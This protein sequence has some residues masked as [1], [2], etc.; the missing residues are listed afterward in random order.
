MNHDVLCGKVSGL[1]D[2]LDLPEPGN[3][4]IIAVGTPMYESMKRDTVHGFAAMMMEMARD[5]PKGN[6]WHL[7]PHNERLTWPFSCYWII[8]SMLA[9]EMIF[10]RKATWLLYVEDDVVVPSNLFEILWREA[11]PEERPFVAAVAYSR[12]EPQLPGITEIGDDG[13]ERQWQA[14]P[15]M[16]LHK[17]ETAPLC[18]T[19]M[20]RNLFERVPQPW[21]DMSSPIIGSASVTGP[22]RHFCKQMK[23]V[24]ISPYV[25]CDVTVG[26]LSQPQII[27]R[28]V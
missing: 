14:A 18:A 17:V 27:G 26:H 15:W 9:Q 12:Y 4:E 5:Y 21:F 20:H 6:I 16:G 7:K 10:G 24:G 3:G 2:P 11:D 19:L 8:R 28:P 13:I 22:A 25:C 23:K 1:I